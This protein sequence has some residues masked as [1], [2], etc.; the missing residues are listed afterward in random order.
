MN[1]FIAGLGLIGGSL[2]KVI[3][4]RTCHLVYG[5]D[6]DEMVC[7][8]ALL[9]GAISRIGD[10]C[11]IKNADIVII[12]LYPKAT[13]DFVKCNL[14]NFKENAIIVDTCGIKSEVCL[15]IARLIKDKNVRFVG[16]HPMAGIERSG[17]EYSGFDSSISPLPMRLSAPETSRMTRLSRPEAT[18]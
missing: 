8:D 17:F 6:K 2:A 12:A 4:K 11:D 5:F 3:S 14:E 18:L 1:I 9:S 15:E 7:R 13:I 10:V 16:G